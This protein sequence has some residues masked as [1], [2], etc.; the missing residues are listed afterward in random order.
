M[1]S[2]GEEKK[3][4]DILAKETSKRYP[5]LYITVYVYLE[6]LQFLK[7]TSNSCRLGPKVVLNFIC[8]LYLDRPRSM[9][10]MVMFVILSVGLSVFHRH[11]VHT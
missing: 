8:N 6:P 11:I 1:M 5:F 10:E 3:S 2:G 7:T 4:D 9:V